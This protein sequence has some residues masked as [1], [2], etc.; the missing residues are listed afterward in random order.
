MFEYNEELIAKSLNGWGFSLNEIDISE[1]SHVPMH[2]YRIATP[3]KPLLY[4]E[5]LQ[6]C[7]G[8]YGMY[9]GFGFAA[10]INPYIMRGD[11]FNI[12]E[13]QPIE[14]NRITNLF[15]TILDNKPPQ[16]ET[17]KIGI[18]YGCNPLSPE[19]YP[20]V[21]MI[22]DGID[23]LIVQLDKMGILVEKMEPQQ[24]IAFILDAMKN[25]LILPET[26]KRS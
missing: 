14:C 24:S 20:T 8:I 2:Q 19:E 22:Y 3:E 9:K 11:D 7:L 21:K 18:F 15:N 10:H 13:G 16:T 5:N 4:V 1:V 23:A 26:R 17:I 6:L 25:E 12:K